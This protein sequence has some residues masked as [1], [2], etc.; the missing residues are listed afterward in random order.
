MKGRKRIVVVGGGSSGVGAAWRAA[1]CGAEV[2]LVECGDM[3]GG[4]S[5]LGGVNVWEPGIA[6]AGL[7]RL[8]FDTL[9]RQ[10][11]AI[12]V[13][14]SVHTYS[15]RTN[16]GMG[17]LIPNL[18]Y[19]QSL[20]RAGM[21]GH[22]M[23]RV[24]FEPVAMHEAM[25]EALYAAGAR[26]ALCTLF[27]GVEQDGE[28]I[29]ALRLR[30]AR[31]QAAYKVAADCVIDCTAEA[32]VARA[33][34]CE[35]LL[36]ED[37]AAAFQEPSAP[38]APMRR[39]NGVSL[40]FRV[41]P[42]P[43]PVGDEAPAWAQ[44]SGAP[45]WLAEHFPASAVTRFPNGDLLFNPLPI[46]QGWEYHQMAPAERQRECRARVH[47]YWDRMKRECGHAG[48]RL[49]SI[50]PRAGVREG[51]RLLA[52][53]MLTEQMVRAGYWRQPQPEQCIALGD[54]PLDTH[55]E[56]P[57]NLRALEPVAQPYG[58][59]LGSLISPVHENLLVAGRCAGFTHLAAASCRLNR[60]MMDL[61]EAAG[62]AA[63]G[64]GDLR[65]ADAARVRSILRFDRY[66]DW[67]AEVYWRIGE[68]MLAWP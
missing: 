48:Y 22:Q 21:A 58:I 56:R 28:R 64:S 25:L 67:V 29:T 45:A 53:T 41:T 50:A 20:R 40:I 47:L 61:G 8:L 65:L 9:Q 2:L 18:P 27:E 37:A 13:G 26:V 17:G 6:S 39:L 23:A 62:A 66:L 55:G 30:D 36:G 59:P 35:T 5:T 42:A 10:P 32:V 34:G 33:A 49:H 11:L 54:H 7:N 31:T 16:T 68:E 19:A 60:T 15:P 52:Q 12:G 51:Y 24:H 44:D 38:Q 4:T 43:S 1:L 57:A 46:M 3:L 63:T 14:R